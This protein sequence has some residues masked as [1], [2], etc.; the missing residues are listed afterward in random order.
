MCENWDSLQI[1]AASSSGLPQPLALMGIC[2]LLPVQAEIP[3]L[4][5]NPMMKS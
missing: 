3:L 5:L 1:L 2:F 4:L